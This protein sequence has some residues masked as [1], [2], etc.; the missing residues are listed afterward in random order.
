M[1]Y[2]SESLHH[3]AEI[4]GVAQDIGTVSQ[5]KLADLAVLNADPLEN[6]RNT[7]ELAFVAKG[8]VLYDAAT[9]DQLWPEKTPLPEQ[10]WWE[11]PP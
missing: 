11:T 6:I 1:P 2:V 4:I 3:G 8:G 10:W 5:G 7:A 9:L